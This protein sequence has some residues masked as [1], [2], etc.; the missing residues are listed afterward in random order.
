MRRLT[1]WSFSAALLAAAALAPPA[2]SRKA[3]APPPHKA[4]RFDGQRA[5][6]RLV[7]LCSFGPRNHGSEGKARAEGWIKAA[8]GEAGA[9]VSAHEFRHAPKGGG[10]EGV[11]RNIVGRIRPE[12][13][14][15]VMF[16]TH[17][18]T[19]SWADRD[20]RPERRG[21]P[22]V[23]A[24]DGASGVAVLLEMAALWKSEP[25][26]VGVDLIFFDGEDFGR[27]Q[28]WDEYFLGSKAWARDFADY[29]PEWGVVVDMVC[30]ASLK[31]RK[32]R[33]SVAR[34]PAVVARLWEAAARVGST[35]FSDEA[36]GRVLDDHTAFLERGLPVALVID[37]EYRWFH[38]SG[39]TPDKCSAE[40]LGQV[41]R[42]LMEALEAP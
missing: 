27:G 29:R 36:G 2:C 30:D 7:E 22:I 1:R 13:S 42:A 25:P 8:L 10:A 16:A 37:F 19:R 32:E 11:F 33:D 4:P 24:N 14:R 26:P 17:Y 23:G 41:G 35:A 15:R 39:D 6:S 9:E 5:Y 18:D 21:E 12:E 28:D 40:S 31:L 20:P 38:T 3:A 34:A